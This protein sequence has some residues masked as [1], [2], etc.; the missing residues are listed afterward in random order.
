MFD[1]WYGD[2]EITTIVIILCA[3]FLLPLQ[4]I[5]CC[6]VK[7]LFLRLLPVT[8]LGAVGGWF[9]ILSLCDSGL[10]GLGYAV[11]AIYAGLML[12]GCTLGW[13]MWA[14]LR[15]CKKEKK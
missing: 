8:V 7:S 9:F 2:V 6:K 12:F 5:L 1:I 15:W 11:L 3:I 4:L 13:G 10:Y 14:M